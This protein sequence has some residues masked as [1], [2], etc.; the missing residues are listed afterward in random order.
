MNIDV[1]LLSYVLMLS[2]QIRV[3]LLLGQVDEAQQ[4]LEFLKEVQAT[5]GKSA[6]SIRPS[7]HFTVETL[8][9]RK[10]L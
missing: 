5:I 7:L 8:F 6:V 10:F 9:C 3:Q 1:V 2:G 4:Q